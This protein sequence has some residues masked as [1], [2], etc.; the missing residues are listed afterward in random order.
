MIPPSAAILT[1]VNSAMVLY[2]SGQNFLL[3]SEGLSETLR[4]KLEQRKVGQGEKKI[5]RGESQGFR[6]TM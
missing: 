1:A 4:R 3:F 5:S 2:K 6:S